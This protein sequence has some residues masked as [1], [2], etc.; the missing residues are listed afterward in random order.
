M[1]HSYV[2]YES[3]TQDSSANPS[4][5]PGAGS[6]TASAAAATVPAPKVNRDMNIGMDSSDT[7]NS[8]PVLGSVQFQCRTAR[9]V[10]WKTWH[11]TVSH[12]VGSF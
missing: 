8:K 11:V 9:T 3:D 4:G 7:T 5:Q 6:V 1:W 10:L 12:C 2:D